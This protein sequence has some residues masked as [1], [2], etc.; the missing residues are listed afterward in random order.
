MRWTSSCLGDVVEK[1]RARFEKLHPEQA[2][3]VYYRSIVFTGK[4]VMPKSFERDSE[5]VKY[6]AKTKGA[7]G[8]V[9]SAADVTGVK[10]LELK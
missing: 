1:S 4:G 3:E 7:V 10:V 9:S 5:V 8:F 2:L 6:V